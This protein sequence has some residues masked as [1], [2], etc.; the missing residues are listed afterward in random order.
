MTINDIISAAL[1]GIISVVA[2]WVAIYWHVATKGTWRDWPAGRSLMGLLAIIT[3]GFGYGVVNRFLGPNWPLRPV[4]S[5]L[6]YALF[7]G[8]I[9]V[10]GLTVRSEMRAGKRKQRQKY[11]THT[12]PVA[13]IV[14]S[15]N[16]EKAE[17][18]V[19]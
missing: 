6:L 15:K 11:P 8:A 7:V 9:I 3:I 19:D 1:L 18:D 5:I 10:I 12:G 14:A 13:V 4:V 16:E 17:E 2:G